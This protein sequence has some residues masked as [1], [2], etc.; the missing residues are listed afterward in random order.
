MRTISPVTIASG[1][2]AGRAGVDLPATCAL[3]E[4][5]SAVSAMSAVMVVRI[6]ANPQRIRLDVA[7]SIWSAAVMTLAFIS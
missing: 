6:M 2:S 1:L 5:T 3:A 7:D 4:T